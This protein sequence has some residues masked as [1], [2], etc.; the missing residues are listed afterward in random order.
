MKAKI[1]LGYL[2]YIPVFIFSYFILNMIFVP[3]INL[4][5]TFFDYI[6]DIFYSSPQRGFLEEVFARSFFIKLLWNSIDIPLSDFSPVE[7]NKVF[8]FK[9]VGSGTI[10]FDNFYFKK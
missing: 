9:I 4:I 10:F 2:F 5:F 3:I 7:L 6:S 8:Q 1:I